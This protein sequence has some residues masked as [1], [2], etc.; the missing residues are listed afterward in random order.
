MPPKKIVYHSLLCVRHFMRI[1][2]RVLTEG[3]KS[4]NSVALHG[5]AMPVE[6]KDVNVIIHYKPDFKVSGWG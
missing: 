1:E 5:L 4:I 6:M 3:W 2:R